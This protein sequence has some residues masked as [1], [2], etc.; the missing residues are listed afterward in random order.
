MFFSAK[1]KERAERV[2][3]KPPVC[4]H[5][6]VYRQR[7]AK[8]QTTQQYLLFVLTRGRKLHIIRWGPKSL[9]LLPTPSRVDEEH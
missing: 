8:V 7:R 9:I 3:L 4:P 6:C 5:A 1:F 2:S